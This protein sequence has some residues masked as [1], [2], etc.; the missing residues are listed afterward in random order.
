MTSISERAIEILLKNTAQ[1]INIRVLDS[2]GDPINATNGPHL[3]VLD[4]GDNIIYKDSYPSFTLTG[5]VTV[6][7]GSTIVNG[8]NTKF[9]TEL[10]EGDTVTIAT[11][12]HT[13]DTVD[14][15]TRFTLTAAHVAG[16]TNATITKA[17][18]I[19]QVSPG[20]YYIL[21][22]STS[23]PSNTP[24]QTE[25]ATARQLLFQW[26]VTGTSGTE[27][28]NTVQTAFV[29]SAKTA[30]LLPTLKRIVDKA[31]Q[32]V[33]E[34]PDD[35][36]YVGYSDWM[37]VDAL[38]KG[39]GWI[40]AF[41]PYPMWGSIDDFPSAHTRILID[42]AVCDLLTSQEL[43]AVATDINY[44]DQGNVFVMEHQPKLSAILNATWQRLVAMVPPMKK[45]YLENGAVRVEAGPNFRFQQLVTAA[46]HG[47]LFRNIFSA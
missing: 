1:R 17:T 23:A 25:T 46:P 11:V 7:A 29:I 36:V 42:A 18:R 41:Q 27:E 24:D 15:D 30:S 32:A 47:S 22:G 10:T 39:L 8:T 40:N 34:N 44:S 16:A 3:T 43:F 28:V 37:L 35:P 38:D 4:L 14:S 20:G 21:W 5:T 31:A 19:S 6:A 12:P 45:H 33:D 9:L 2:N 13:V 26:R